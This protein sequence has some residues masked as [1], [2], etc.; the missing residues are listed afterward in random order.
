MIDIF[1]NHLS[2]TEGEFLVLFS[3]FMPMVRSKAIVVHDS[4][5]NRL[6]LKSLDK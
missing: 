1:F 2:V 5:R 6:E 3:P 4:N